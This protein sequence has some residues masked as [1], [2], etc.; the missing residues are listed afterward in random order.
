MRIVQLAAVTLLVTAAA[1]FTI[2]H[3][4]E[5]TSAAPAL[6]GPAPCSSATRLSR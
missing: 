2:W 6:R 4:V 3:I 1:S 5:T